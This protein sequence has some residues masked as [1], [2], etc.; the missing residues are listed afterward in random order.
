MSPTKKRLLRWKRAGK[1]IRRDTYPRPKW[2][3]RYTRK[4]HTLEQAEARYYTGAI[5]TMKQVP[6]EF[7]RLH[8]RKRRS[9][10][11]QALRNAKAHRAAPKFPVGT[12]HWDEEGVSDW[13]DFLFDVPCRRDV[14]W[15]YW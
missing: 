14:R 2:L 5:T 15:N 6:A 4:G 9:Q 3:Y 13:D 1:T 12:T 10:L 8:N 11:S 7:R